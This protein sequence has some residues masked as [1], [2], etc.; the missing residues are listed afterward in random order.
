VKYAV[1][2]EGL[3]TEAGEVKEQPQGWCHV[4]MRIQ[5]EGLLSSLAYVK[6]I[7]N[8]L[9]SVSNGLVLQRRV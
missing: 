3:C 9:N 5:S 7:P 8:P 4:G 2:R 1:W 6:E